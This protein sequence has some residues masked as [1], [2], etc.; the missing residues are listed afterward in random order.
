VPAAKPEDVQE[1]GKPAAAA[2]GVTFLRHEN[3]KALFD[4]GSGE[5]EFTASHP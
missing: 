2:P 4:V 1:S 3:G 5:Y